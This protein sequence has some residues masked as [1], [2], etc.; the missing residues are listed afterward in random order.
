M[1]DEAAGLVVAMVDPREGER[2][3]DACA[4]PGGKSL[5]AATRLNGWVR[6]HHRPPI[7]LRASPSR[8]GE[9]CECSLPCRCSTAEFPGGCRPP[10]SP[11][12]GMN[13]TSLASVGPSRLLAP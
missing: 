13:L 3:L 11:R 12:G 7:D 8:V 2:L 6:P 4:A 10:N 1:Q 5:F 9:H